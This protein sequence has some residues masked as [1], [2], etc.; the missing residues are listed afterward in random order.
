[1]Q[2]GEPQESRMGFKLGKVSTRGINKP[3]PNSK[4]CG[5]NLIFDLF[6]QKIF[7]D[8]LDRV[9]FFMDAPLINIQE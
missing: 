3:T 2:E 6:Q 7:H 5:F 1:M 4:T 9:N 8:L